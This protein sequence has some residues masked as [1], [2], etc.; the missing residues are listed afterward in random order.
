[1]KTKKILA[2]TLAICMAISLLPA[3]AAFASG[4]TTLYIDKGPITIGDGTLS[5]YDADGNSV[6]TH[7]PNGYIITQTK[8]ANSTANTITVSGGTHSITL[9]GVNI[10]VSANSSVCA[11][12]IAGGATVNL[13]LEENSENTLKSGFER[14]GLGV[15]GGAILNI[16]ANGS[17]DNAGKLTATGGQYSAGIGGFGRHDYSG[18]SGNITINGGSVTATGGTRGAGIGG[19]AYGSGG[20]IT[21]NGGSV[22]AIGRSD[23]INGGAGI[24]G[25]LNGN[26]GNI[27]INGGSVTAT[28]GTCGAGIGGASG[29]SGG[30]ITISGGTITANGGLD[31]AGIGNGSGGNSGNITISGGTIIAN[32]GSGFYTANDPAGIGRGGSSSVNS[33]NITISGGDITAKRGVTITKDSTIA[34]GETLILREGTIL[35]VADGVTLTNKGRIINKSGIDING[36]VTSSGGTIFTAVGNISDV[37]TD[38]FVNTDLSLS[39]T[40]TPSTSTNQTI[41]WSV[42]EQNGTGASI[43]GNTFRATT[44]GLSGGTTIVT[45]TIENGDYDIDKQQTKDYTQDFTVHVNDYATAPIRLREES[46]VKE[47]SINEGL[48]WIPYTGDI[49]I[50]NSAAAA[51]TITVISGEHNITL[52]GVNIA[53]TSH[54]LSVHSGATLNLTLADGSANTLRN[55]LTSGNNSWDNEA[56]RVHGTLN[57]DGGGS[58]NAGSTYSG[59]G[60]AVH[61]RAVLHIKGGTITAN[62]NNAAGIGTRAGLYES[63]G[64]IRIS[65]GTVTA[66]GNGSNPGIGLAYLANNYS[67]GAIEISGGTVIANGTSGYGGDGIGI[68]TA[69]DNKNYS[70]SVTITGGTVTAASRYGSGSAIRNLTVSP[71]AD[72]AITVKTG[73]SADGTD[74]AEIDG[75]PFTV[76][77]GG[78]AISSSGKYLKSGTITAYDVNVPVGVTVKNAAGTEITQAAEGQTV[79]ILSADGNFSAW[80]GAETLTFTGGTSALSNPASFIM[81][82]SAVSLDILTDEIS[83]ADDLVLFRNAVNA[84]NDFD[85]KT[86]KLMNDIDLSTVCGETLGVSWEPIGSVAAPFRGV[87][88]GGMFEI[89]GLYINGSANDQGLFGVNMDTIKNLGVTGSVT[90]R[91]Y[92]GGIAGTNVGNGHIQNCYNEAAVKGISQGGGI[93][94]RNFG[95]IYNCYN[96]GIITIGTD[97]GGIAGYNYDNGTVENCYSTDTVV[98]MAVYGA[99]IGTNSGTASNLYHPENTTAIGGAGGMFVFNENIAATFNKSTM[100]LTNSETLLVEKLNEWVKTTADV[101]FYTWKAKSDTDLTPIFDEPYDPSVASVTVGGVTTKHLTLAEAIAAVNASSSASVDGAT[102]T[103]LKDVSS[104]SNLSMPTKP[105]TIDGNGKTW[106]AVLDPRLKADTR[107]KNIVLKRSGSDL[108][109]LHGENK[110]VYLNNVSAST[111]QKILLHNASLVIEA[112]G[113]HNLYRMVNVTSIRSEGGGKIALAPG[114]MLNFSYEDNSSQ[115]KV[116]TLE[117]QIEMVFAD[118]GR[119][120]VVKKDL[121][122]SSLLPKLLLKKSGDDDTE[123]TLKKDATINTA[124]YYIPVEVAIEKIEITSPSDGFTYSSGD[125]ASYYGLMVTITYNNKTTISYITIDDFD[126]YGLTVTPQ[127]NVSASDEFKP[128]INKATITGGTAAA[129]FEVLY[130]PYQQGDSKILPIDHGITEVTYTS[131]AIYARPTTEYEGDTYNLGVVGDKYYKVNDDGTVGDE[132]AEPILPGRYF[133]EADAASA[134]TAEI[135]DT[136]TFEGY[137]NRYV[138]IADTQGKDA[139]TL[140]AAYDGYGILTITPAAQQQKPIYFAAGMVNKYVT[141]GTF[142]NA[143]TNENEN[144]TVTYSSSNEGVATVGTDG[145]VTIRGEGTATILAESNVT[146]MTPVYASY[147][148]VVS[149]EPITV[150]LT[151]GASEYPYGTEKA[152][153]L[154][155]VSAENGENLQALG[156]TPNI[157]YEQGDGAGR[158]EIYATVAENAT[159]DISVKGASFRIVPKT[160][161]AN[162]FT[163]FARNKYYDGTINAVV[164]AIVKDASKLSGDVL[165]VEVTGSFD[166]ANAGNA[167]RVSYA[168]TGLGGADSGNYAIAATIQGSTSANITKAQVTLSAPSNTSYVYDGEEKSVN[169]VGYVAGM[170][171]QGFSVT[172]DGSAALPTEQG[173]Y[174]VDVTLDDPDNYEIAQNINS[175]LTIKSAAQDVFTIEGIPD[176]V[177]YGDTLTLSAAGA[178]TG[179]AISY[180]VVSGNAQLTG[181]SLEITGTGTVQIKATSTLAN[182]EDKTA[183]RTFTVG[184]KVLSP[185]VRLARLTREYDGTTDIDVAVDVSAEVLAGDNVSASA[186]GAMATADAGTGKTVF[187]SG[188]TLG[189]ADK[190]KYTLSITTIHSFRSM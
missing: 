176:S 113:L 22:T 42:K 128:G 150:T 156:I 120:L 124:D 79:T 4:E 47:Y 53:S 118:I 49:R 39:G 137:A 123:Y 63:V 109:A 129:T 142:A 58:L 3:N 151:A 108:F 181:N 177:S 164:S 36:A 23:G 103:L 115:Y 133:Y 24:G 121:D 154:N 54:P 145:T 171:F 76:R 162:D 87:F 41:V 25:G 70:G 83:T 100:K 132:I 72:T 27:T 169:V 92:V 18:G 148:L 186:T 102:I 157:D 15:P 28:G 167:K 117:N 45:A 175:T 89:S 99:L 35:T 13:T 143:L 84:G 33:D 139:E 134:A 158:Y 44:G 40:V 131:S 90:G 2:M 7:N 32:G 86:V 71:A 125:S 94:G 114:A 144:S 1:M 130:Q 159:Y 50:A 170:V 38:A 61:S 190:D 62:G 37:P 101:S 46:G 85:G 119:S 189:G 122:I 160:L 48:D 149:K 14:A 140:A 11:F 64:T 116:T 172:Y 183:T 77:N 146:G 141:S 16:A 93:A 126:T 10:N 68:G 12:S 185:M 78:H 19:G 59:A 73:T 168:I 74:A 20:N 52:A 9:N 29:G 155:G 180:Q 6:T 178:P 112:G 75:S 69:N 88:D 65:G 17:G 187:V 5:G 174:D 67:F 96:T 66:T 173:V 136:F 97:A 188:I 107:F 56:V 135:D 98:C 82:D 153:I 55:T 51:N 105:C 184:R 166:D 106:T 127:R 161:T 179:S 21:I 138:D 43:T 31:G 165:T 8:V 26:G 110:K 152:E 34:D 57:I 60:I 95:D 81:P 111:D 104:D 30:N 182:Y 80:T 147:T 163:V 91:N